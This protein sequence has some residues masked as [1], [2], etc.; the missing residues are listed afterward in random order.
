MYLHFI[1]DIVMHV[2]GLNTRVNGQV[3][4]SHDNNNCK[5]NRQDVVKLSG[6]YDEVVLR[7]LVSAGVLVR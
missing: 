2:W 1:V 3:L 7:C 5:Y 4:H 6:G